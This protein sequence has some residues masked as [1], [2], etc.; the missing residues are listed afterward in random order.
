MSIIGS[1]TMHLGQNTLTWVVGKMQLQ[2]RVGDVG[3]EGPNLSLVRKMDVAGRSS[4]SALCMTVV[5]MEQK[6]PPTGTTAVVFVQHGQIYLDSY[7]CLKQWEKSKKHDITP[8]IVAVCHSTAVRTRP[9]SFQPS[10]KAWLIVFLFIPDG[11][12]HARRLTFY[13]SVIYLQLLCTTY[14]IVV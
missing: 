9:M 7:N 11:A 14:C 8:L 6:A 13:T 3:G 4:D 1:G 5:L 12:F 10:A 2:L